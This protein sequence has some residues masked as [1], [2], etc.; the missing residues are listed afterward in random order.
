M[1]SGPWPGAIGGTG[2]LRASTMTASTREPG[3]GS[4]PPTT[5]DTQPPENASP[6][7]GGSVAGSLAGRVGIP[8]PHPATIGAAASPAPAASP[9]RSTARRRRPPG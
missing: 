4:A 8:A 6:S 9:A 3:A 7:A 2:R 5:A 1:L